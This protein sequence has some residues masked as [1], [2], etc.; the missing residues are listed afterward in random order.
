MKKISLLILLSLFNT[1]AFSAAPKATRLAKYWGRTKLATAFAAG[2]YIKL[3]D[4]DNVLGRFV[5]KLTDNL[6][7]DI[8]KL[9]KLL[10]LTVRENEKNHKNTITSQ[11]KIDPNNSNS[12]NES[13]KTTES[14]DSSQTN[15]AA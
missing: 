11:S 1:Y 6:S 2:Y 7:G 12:N 4:T 9:S 14:N 13:A 5:S 10:A 8:E 15:D 3:Q